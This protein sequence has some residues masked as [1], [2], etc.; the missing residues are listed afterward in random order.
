MAEPLSIPPPRRSTAD[1]VAIVV[2]GNAKQVTDELVEV[3]D[4]L[5]Q[6]GDLYVSRSLEEGQEIA[7]TIVERGYPT[8]LTG[9]GDGTFVQVVTW[10]NQAAKKRGLPLPRFGFLRLGTGNALAWVVGAQN[11]RGRGVFA[12]L[13]RLRKE[14]GSRQLRLLEVEGLLTPFA[15]TGTDAIVLSHFEG[16]KA[17]FARTPV[18]ERFATGGAAYATAIVTRSIPDQI[19]RPSRKVRIVNEGEDTRRI[20]PDGQ[21]TGSLV[22]RGEVIY[23]GPSRM[24]IFSTIPYWGFGAR[25]FPFAAD[26]EDRFQLRVVDVGPLMLASHVRAIWKGTYTHPGIHDFL[27]DHISVHYEQPMPLQVG[28][29]LIGER[30]DYDAR[31]YPEPIRVVDYYGPPPVD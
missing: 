23:E 10:V 14:G 20:G 16:V 4:Q 9:G 13:G 19:A 27:V 18:L 29:D 5:V 22:R 8:V 15:G 2:N 30:S 3:L 12:D 31:L 11:I 7:E 28:G 1:R 26:R 6:S 24:V 17:I 21:P 25:I